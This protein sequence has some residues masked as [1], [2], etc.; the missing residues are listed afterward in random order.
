MTDALRQFHEAAKRQPEEQKYQHTILI[1]DKGLHAIPW[2]SLDC[3]RERSISRLPSLQC[4][5]ERILQQQGHAQVL[6]SDDNTSAGY[7]V[8]RSNGAYIL[9]PSGD[10]KHTQ[11]QFEG[12]LQEFFSWDGVVDQVPSESEMTG[13]LASKDILLYFGHGSGSQFIRRRSI[14]G[15]EQCAVT[16]LMGCSSGTMTEAGE[17]E[18]YGTPIDYIN[19]GAPALVATLWD[20]T[21]K[22]IDRFSMTLLQE[23]GLFKSRTEI[24]TVGQTGSNPDQRLKGRGKGKEAP[25]TLEARTPKSAVSLCEAVAIA[26]ESCTTKYLNGAAPVVYGVP[27]FVAD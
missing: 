3:L 21:D 22:D 13:F 16:L 6:S 23:W 25:T 19:A 12:P 26:R 20:V 11:A 5:R 2:E 14:M 8:R 27:V 15:L 1:L 4:L 7:S 17:F 10:L 9:N 24:P 18:S